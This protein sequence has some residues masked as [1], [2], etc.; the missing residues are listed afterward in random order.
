MKSI[1]A[2]RATATASL[3]AAS[4]ALAG[5]AAADGHALSEKVSS[6][7]YVMDVTHG[8]V[9]FSYNHL[10][11]SNP[12]LRFRTVDAKLGLDAD[13][14]AASSVNVTIAA[15][16][17]DT[18]VDVFDG[19][20]NSADWLDTEAYPE[21]TFV[22]TALE[23]TDSG[24]GTLTGDLTIKGVTKP[25]T[26]DVTLIGAGPHPLNQ[27][28]TVGVEATG[29]V[30]RSEFGLGNFVPAVSDEVQILI[31]GEFNKVEEEPQGS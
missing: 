16:S 28:E 29:T 25:V 23:Q 27:K 21:I 22:S 13:D 4:L 9:T 6:G 31:S 26:L 2:L 7:D 11:F 10:G 15:N 19:H 8:Y 14:P 24:T 30:L 3:L 20:M 18:G 17:I 1:T 12:Q 5:T